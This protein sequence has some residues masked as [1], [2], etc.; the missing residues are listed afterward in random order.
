[1]NNVKIEMEDIILETLEPKIYKSLMKKVKDSKRR[2]ESYIKEFI[3]P[4]IK[5]L[6]MSRIDAEV[7]GR[8]KNYSSIYHKMKN[9]E[10][11]FVEIFDLFAI[12]IIVNENDQCYNALGL[13]HQIYKPVQNRFKDYIANPK[14]NGYQSIHTTVIG[15][16]GKNVEVQIRTEKMNRTAEVGI[17]A[18]WVYKQ[19]D[20]E[21]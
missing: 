3:S 11:E 13:T 16:L 4:L 10:K 15:A 9:R 8:A 14:Q 2:R 5:E 7:F 21:Y 6:E 1:M 12:R 20:E 19:S 18:H 17:A